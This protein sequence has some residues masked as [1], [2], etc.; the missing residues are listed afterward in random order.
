S[1]SRR[2]L[3]ATCPTPASARNSG[4]ARQGQPHRSHRLYSRAGV[5]SCFMNLCR[6]VGGRAARGNILR[7]RTRL[8]KKLGR[9][10]S[11]FFARDENTE[12]NQP[13]HQLTIDLQ[14]T[15]GGNSRERLC[16]GATV[17]VGQDLKQFVW[18]FNRVVAAISADGVCVR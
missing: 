15:R 14:S 13:T 1:R 3:R 5:C 11:L 12:V 9:P 6:Q 2:R 16:D 7:P 17:E 8:S 18:Q 4:R 10:T